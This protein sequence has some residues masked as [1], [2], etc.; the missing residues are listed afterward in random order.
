MTTFPA[1]FVRLLLAA[2]ATA[3]AGVSTAQ[4]KSW[5][6]DGRSGSQS[7]AGTATAPFQT[8]WQAMKVVQPGDTVFVLPTT[9][10]PRLSVTVSGTATAPIRV[11]GGE[12]AGGFT[13]VAGTGAD[14]AVWIN[15]DYVSVS[16]FDASAAEQNAAFSVAPNHHHVTIANNLIHDAGAAGITAV[17]DDYVT[18]SN[19]AVYG[20]AHITAGSWQS[21][22]ISLLGMVDID[23][24]KGI[25]NRIDGNVVYG[26]TNIPYCFDAFCWAHWLNSDGSGII[27]DDF[28]R[29][30]F[31]GVT[32]GG[33]TLISN[34]VVFGNGGRG[35]YLYRSLHA[36]IIGNTI[37][38]NNRDPF[39][40]NWRPGEIGL[41]E[42]GDV[43][44]YNN[45]L[46]S[47]SKTSPNR[48]G[49]A[50]NTHV[51]FSAEYCSTGSGRIILQHNLIYNPQHEPS[52]MIYTRDNG[53][54][55]VISDN[56]WAGASLVRPSLDPAMADFRPRSDSILVG[57]GDPAHAMERDIG[58]VLRTGRT[59]IGAYEAPGN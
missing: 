28:M 57:N 42:A 22:G 36:D 11:V 53:D 32:Y 13:Q 34:N 45:V 40:G 56:L 29:K 16:Q 19:N 37:V 38:Y 46:Y 7:N 39:E 58:G 50:P 59:T 55:V 2:V 20:N 9:V 5:Y 51:G 48:T 8:P 33:R 47:D 4:A 49:T 41:N 44:I 27:L 17:A 54:E 10:Y 21:S 52:Q 6:V 31:D 14:S 12:A 3:S 30:R 43:A 15:A 18:I 23:D 25:K 1:Q 26:N 35:I 24:Y